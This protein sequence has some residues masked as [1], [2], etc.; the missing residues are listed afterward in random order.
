MNAVL[1]I[2]AGP[3]QI[4]PEE[5]VE[6]IAKHTKNTVSPSAVYIIS[7]AE[8]VDKILKD[9]KTLNDAMRPIQADASIGI[10]NYTANG[11]IKFNCDIRGKS[12]KTLNLNL[13][14]RQGLTKLF[15]DRGG[16]VESGT[17]A[18]FVKPSKDKDNRFLHASHALSEGAEV[19]FTALWL[20]PYIASQPRVVHLDTSAVAS[21][22]LAATVMGGNGACPIITTFN[23]YENL[24]THNFTQFSHDLIIISASQTGSMARKIATKA[25]RSDIVT[26]FSLIKDEGYSDLPHVLCDLRYEENKNPNGIKPITPVTDSDNSRPIKL[27][28]QHFVAQAHPLKP[29]VPA[30]ADAPKEIDGW[31][32]KLKG[33]SIFRILI[34]E[35][36]KELSPVSVDFDVL[37]TQKSFLKWLEKTVARNVPASTQSVLYEGTDSASERMSDLINN[38]YG[39]QKKTKLKFEKKTI[40]D[41]ASSSRRNKGYAPYVVVEACTSNGGALLAASRALRTYAADSHREYICGVAISESEGAFKM[42]N[43]NLCFPT[44]RFTCMFNLSIKRETSV[45]SWAAE[46]ELLKK[47]S[48]LPAALS[49]RSN[50]LSSNKHLIEDLFLSVG[51]NALA[52]RDNFAFWPSISSC[53][54]ASQADV[55]LTMAS[56]LENMRTG[57]SKNTLINDIQSESVI[58]VETFSRYN[59][60]IIQAAILRAAHP[61]ELNY[62]ESANESRLLV[63]LIEEMLDY[64]YQQQGEALNEF[65]LALAVGR[66]KVEETTEKKFQERLLNKN[67]GRNAVGEWLAKRYGERCT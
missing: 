50:L 32:A 34:D 45:H 38:A 5:L 22:V 33:N 29:I 35:E 51:K 61:M 56:I 40:A 9:K 8:N 24:D 57:S 19:F 25:T 49:R 31:V 54:D 7:S 43:S 44:H 4:E 28:S 53:N 63:G 41:V 46:R 2:F 21:V 39:K 12:S 42:L 30:K 6:Q 58:A 1:V 11:R 47:H 17:T 10:Y 26:L 15:V 18:H 55:Y 20:L 62:K 23:S 36:A 65:L 16:L 3:Y 13:I 60:G 66:I 59:D 48:K 67:F 14:R 52:L 37:V 64:Q 27:I